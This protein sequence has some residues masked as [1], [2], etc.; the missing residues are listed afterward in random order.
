MRVVG[1][2]VS[3]VEPGPDPASDPVVRLYVDRALS[4][5]PRWGG[6]VVLDPHGR[7]VLGRRRYERALRS[8]ELVVP[9][10]RVDVTDEEARLLRLADFAESD[11]LLMLLLERIVAGGG[12]EGG[13]GGG[14]EIGRA[15]V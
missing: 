6:V 7:I 15:H 2:N 4:L 13:G 1:M 14:G 3:Q 12:V 5:G 11:G 9:T 10:T 8:H